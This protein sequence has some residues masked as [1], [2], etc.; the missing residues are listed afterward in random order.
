MTKPSKFL[1]VLLYTLAGTLLLIM[2]STV[3]KIFLGGSSLAFN[4]HSYVV[5]CIV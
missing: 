3:Q 4:P 5:P 1:Q 2:L